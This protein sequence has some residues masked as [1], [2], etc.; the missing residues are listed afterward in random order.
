MTEV[1]NFA[2]IQPQQLTGGDLFGNYAQGK[3]LASAIEQAKALAA[4]KS[5]QAENYDRELE[6]KMAYQAASGEHLRQDAARMA[7]DLNN[8][9]WNVKPTGNMANAWVINAIKGQYGENSPQY[10][11]AKQ[12]YDASLQKD[13]LLNTYR[14]SLIDTAGKRASTSLGKTIM[15]SREAN[16]GYAPGTNREER[17][18]PEEQQ[19]ISGEYGLSRQKST[20]DEDTRKKTLFASNI[21]K[22]LSNINVDHLT[23]Y[24]GPKGTLNQKL[25]EAQIALGKNPKRYQDYTKAVTGATA[26]AKQVRQFY[27][28]SIQPS[29][30]EKLEQITNP[31]TWKNNPEV[32]S[33]I[34]NQFA[35]ILKQETATYKNALRNTGE[36]RQAPPV[37]HKSYTKADVEG[38]KRELPTWSDARIIKYLDEKTGGAKRG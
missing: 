6:S 37:Q 2:G 12:A 15:E 8:P 35:N 29:V 36:F 4:Y 9:Y 21:D 1:I 38:L 13:R 32:A 11:S 20:T 18:S 3:K 34:F 10:Q 22:T 16:Q 25:D 17:L 7:K 19:Q 33:Q 31:A 26:L 24:A 14:E 23:Q 28:D 5:K 27:G 30:A